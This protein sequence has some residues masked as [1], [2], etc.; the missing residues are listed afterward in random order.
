MIDGRRGE[1]NGRLGVFR[2]VQ[3]GT[4]GIHDL[5]QGCS[6]A[7]LEDGI[8]LVHQGFDVRKGVVK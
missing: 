5:Q 6:P 3:R 4:A 1:K 7:L 2:L 8:P